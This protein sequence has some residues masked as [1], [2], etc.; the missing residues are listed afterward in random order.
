MTAT[1]LNDEIS[2]TTSRSDCGGLRFDV[3]SELENSGVSVSSIF[4]M[5]SMKF[6]FGTGNLTQR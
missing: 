6:N 3:V 1:L 4:L 5:P 2:T